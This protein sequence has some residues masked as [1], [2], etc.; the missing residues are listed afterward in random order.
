MQSLESQLPAGHEL[1]EYTQTVFG[2]D[3]EVTHGWWELRGE[4]A[5]NRFKNP[6]ISGDLKHWSYYVEGR[7]KLS[8]GVYA[9]A[10]WE[11]WIYGH[12]DDP[13]GG[14]GRWGD[15]VERAEFAAGYWAEASLLFKAD[16]QMTRQG[17]GGWKAD[18]K[19]GGVQAVLRF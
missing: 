17:V 9:A 5:E 2:S 4:W 11:E 19:I 18:N 1:S 3:L 6:G 14:R 7:R 12:T 8:A 10:R 15:N 16:F 13:Y